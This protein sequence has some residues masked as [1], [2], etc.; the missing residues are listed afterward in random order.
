MEDFPIDFNRVR[1]SEG[2]FSRFKIIAQAARNPLRLVPEL[3]ALNK[4]AND[5]AGRLGDFVASCEF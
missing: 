5:A 4:R 1:D 3:M 2:R